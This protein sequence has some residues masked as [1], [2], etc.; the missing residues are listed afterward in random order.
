MKGAQALDL[1][2]VHI[3]EI[4]YE[5]KETSFTLSEV[6][7]FHLEGRLCMPNDEDIGKHILSKAHET[8]Y[9]VHPGATKMYQ[10]LKE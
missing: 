4:V 7:I 9:F 6:G 3:I 8:P 10:G 1:E 5:G 2:L